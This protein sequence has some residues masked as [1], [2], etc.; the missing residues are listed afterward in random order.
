LTETIPNS[1]LTTYILHGGRGRVG[2]R[3]SLA[4]FEQIVKH[5]QYPIRLVLAYFA[6]PEEKWTAL[7]ERDRQ[8]FLNI[9]GHEAIEIA[10]ASKQLEEFTRQ[11]GNATA[12]YLSGG[13]T[14][15]LKHM[16]KTVPNLGEAFRGKV[17]AGSS[18]GVHALCC[19]YYNR[20]ADRI[21]RGLGILPLKVFCHYGSSSQKA[22]EQLVSTGE[23]LQVVTI[24]EEQFLTLMMAPPKVSS[25]TC[26]E[27]DPTCK[28]P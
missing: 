2:S 15:T 25:I 17:V 12:I 13:K 3:E 16:L 8:A 10:L 6:L 11:L 23:C 19:Y 5:S 14:K 9:T 7:F 18:A 1:P 24:P 21:D 4:F 20:A 26:N 22:L 27:A 28:V